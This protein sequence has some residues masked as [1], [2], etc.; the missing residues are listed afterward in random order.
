MS[1]GHM[2]EVKLSTPVGSGGAVFG[3][4]VP[5]L[6]FVHKRPYCDTFLQKV[7]MD[8]QLWEAQPADPLLM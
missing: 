7:R 1:T 8:Q 3:P 4:Q 6:Y 5:I 2:V